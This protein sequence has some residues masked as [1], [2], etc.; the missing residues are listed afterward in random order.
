M[1]EREGAG[2]DG[3]G[4]LEALAPVNQKS[5]DQNFLLEGH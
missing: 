5:P 3:K 4:R 1:E 2:K